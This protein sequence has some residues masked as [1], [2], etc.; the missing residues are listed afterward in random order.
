MPEMDEQRLKWMRNRFVEMATRTEEMSEELF[1]MREELN[2]V[3]DY[4][5]KFLEEE[6]D[7]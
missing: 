7:D 4:L 5:G 1:R 6:D 2:Q 3:I